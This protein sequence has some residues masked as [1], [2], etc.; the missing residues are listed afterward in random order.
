MLGSENGSTAGQLLAAVHD[1]VRWSGLR[2]SQVLRRAG[3]DP[4][5]LDRVRGGGDITLRTHDDIRAYMSA[6]RARVE[7]QHAEGERAEAAV[8]GAGVAG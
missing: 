3:V 1:F 4:R 7:R 2:E 6:E 5:C 8:R